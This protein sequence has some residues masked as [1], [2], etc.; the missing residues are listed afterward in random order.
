MAFLV[1]SAT[2][3]GRKRI[4]PFRDRC[5]LGRHPNCDVFD[6]FEQNNRVSR[7]HAELMQ[8]GECCYV[9]DNQSRNGTLVN[10]DRVAEET[11]LRDGDRLD[12][13]G[14][15]LIFHTEDPADELEVP[16]PP[17]ETARGTVVLDAGRPSPISSVDVEVADVS[18]AKAKGTRAEARLRALVQVLNNLG[19]SLDVEA[20]LG[21]L[22]EGLFEV[23]P[24]AERGFV[25]LTADDGRGV[26]PRVTRFRQQ[27]ESG[28]IR[29]SRSIIEH[30]L[31]RK[32][33]ILSADVSHDPQLPATSSLVEFGANSFVCAPL[34]ATEDPPLGVV[35]LDTGSSARSFSQDDLDVLVGVV[36]QAA[37]AVRHAQLYEQA[38]RRQALEHD[39]HLARRVQLGLLPEREPRIDGYDFF[40]YYRAAY[41]VGGDYYDFVTLPGNRLAVLVADVAGKGVSA[42]LLMAKL[43]GEVKYYLSCETVRSAFER[44]NESLLDSGSG[45]FVTLVVMVVEIDTGRLTV[46]NAGH[47]TPLLRRKSGAVDPVAESSRGMALGILPGQQYEECVSC[48]APGEA[49][50]AF[51]DGF[52]E[53]TNTKGEMYGLDRLQR[54]LGCGAT[55]VRHLGGCILEDVQA[56]VGEHSQSDDMCLVGVARV[57]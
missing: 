16:A 38:L 56:F 9:R 13:C 42:A 30:V 40:T 41:D 20:T 35:H 24:Q 6:V 51:T 14:V 50:F 31:S 5:V 7:F 36:S 10:G 11:A 44:M 57:P 19:T 8:V 21:D 28:T 32:Q 3:L 22:L 33:A 27:G 37:L 43:S 12:I 2:A 23:F 15:E 18:A 46:V 49:L 53:A 47:L 45:R 48:L 34:L 17:I 29:A 25:A 54:G 1:T 55:G 39:M 4:Y 52:S 26:V